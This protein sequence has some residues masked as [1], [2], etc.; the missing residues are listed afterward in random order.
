MVV[1]N[2]QPIGKGARDECALMSSSFPR[3]LELLVG[4][5]IAFIWTNKGELNRAGV[6]EEAA[7][8]EDHQR[9]SR[10]Q[11]AVTMQDKMGAR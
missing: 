2:L 1:Y 8:K 10:L 6:E 7:R 3:P 9:A 4:D 5:F 11:Y